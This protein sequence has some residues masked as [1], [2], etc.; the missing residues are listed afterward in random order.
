M[1]DGPLRLAC[2][3]MPRSTGGVT[4]ALR[5]RTAEQRRAVAATTCGDTAAARGRGAVDLQWYDRDRQRLTAECRGG[6]CGHPYRG[7]RRCS[8]T[9]G[10]CRLDLASIRGS[11]RGSCPTP[12]ASTFRLPGFHR[13]TRCLD[14]PRC[15]GR[16]RFSF[17]R[18]LGESPIGV[19]G[20]FRRYSRAF[21]WPS[22]SP[23]PAAF[24]AS[25]AAAVMSVSP[26]GSCPFSTQ[27]ATV[28]GQDEGQLP[29][30]F[31]SP[32]EPLSRRA[33]SLPERP[34]PGSG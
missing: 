26:D 19:L 6:V 4:R 16:V 34:V 27:P 32:L 1:S 23:P 18:E 30:E 29:S 2:V 5:L 22:L 25:I 24:R 8:P 21:C 11:P 13:L 9:I 33:R 28:L 31:C 10:Y 14:R 17:G 3:Q 7:W 20:N 12:S 15:G